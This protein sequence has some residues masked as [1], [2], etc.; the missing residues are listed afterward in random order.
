MVQRSFSKSSI[1]LPTLRYNMCLLVPPR[2]GSKGHKSTKTKSHPEI[3]PVAVPAIPTHSRMPHSK[4]CASSVTSPSCHTEHLIDY[5]REKYPTESTT[6][7]Q[8]SHNLALRHLD[9]H[10]HA[11]FDQAKSATEGVGKGIKQIQ[12]RLERMDEILKGTDEA[13]KSARD[14]GEETKKR[15]SAKADEQRKVKE[16]AAKKELE[17]LKGLVEKQE[18]ESEEQKNKPLPKKGLEE[19]DVLKLIDERDMRQELERLRGLQKGATPKHSKEYLGE[20]DLVEILDQRDHERERA[21]LQALENQKAE[22]SKQ[23]SSRNISV[24]HGTSWL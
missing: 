6:W 1:V 3:K 23:V 22:E 24:C 14:F 8:Y 10:V 20:A 7:E 18:K 12:E 16:D 9:E 15:R 17:R 13:A 4:T 5:L 2:K 11:E 21:R 19:V